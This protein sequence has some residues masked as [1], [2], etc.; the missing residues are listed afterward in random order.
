V[1]LKNV[2]IKGN[3]IQLDADMKI[4]GD[5]CTSETDVSVRIG[6]TGTRLRASG[7]IANPVIRPALSLS[8]SAAV[9]KSLYSTETYLLEKLQ[10]TGAEKCQKK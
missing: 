7:P 2:S 9:K 10:P 6:G 4:D 8:L 5:D 1:A 3:S